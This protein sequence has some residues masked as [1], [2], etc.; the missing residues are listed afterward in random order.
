MEA[1][2]VLGEH[3]LRAYCC[4]YLE[5]NLKDKFGA[6]AGLPAMF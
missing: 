2:T 3:C 1:D 6:K 5:G 4:K